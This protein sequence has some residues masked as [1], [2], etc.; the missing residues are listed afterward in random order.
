MTGVFEEREHG[1]E[2]KWVHDEET[3]FRIMA[4]RD[5]WLGKWAAEAMQ[6]PTSDVDRY[7]KE[8]I[9]AGLTGKG[10]EPVLKKIRQDF[11]MRMLGCPDAV[12]ETKMK[13][14]FDQA[15]EEILE[16]KIT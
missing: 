11:S 14:L 16:K 15:S 10:K 9:N 6:L 2:A 3:L 1:Y 13:D 4:K 5:A 8:V 7:I 12:I